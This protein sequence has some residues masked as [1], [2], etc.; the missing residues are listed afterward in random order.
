MVPSLYVPVA[1]QF[2]EVVGASIALPGVTEMETSVAVLTFSGADPETP[3][4]VAEM[5]AV[6]GLTA[7]A[8]PPAETVATAVLSEAHVESSVMFWFVLSLKRPAAVKGNL[9]PGAMVRP[10]GVTVTE[11]I[12]ALETLSGVDPLIEPSVAVI[13]VVPGVRVCARP[14]IV[15]VAT[16]VLDEL[17]ETCWVKL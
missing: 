14:P 12:V 9:V 15:I 3:L 17:Q 8:A 2:I 16:A 13:V 6:P 5:L 7:D 4:K 11:T 1:T 10:V